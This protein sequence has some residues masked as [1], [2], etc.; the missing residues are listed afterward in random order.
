[1]ASL[2]FTRNA[3][4]VSSDNNPVLCA[5]ELHKSYGSGD[6]IVH[7]VAGVDVALHAGEVVAIMGAS[8]S[9]KTT[10]LH[11]LAGL[12]RADSGAICF[13]DRDFATL[14]DAQL[15]A[16]RCAELSI[17]FQ[18]YN[19]LP[20]LTAIDNVALP[21]LLGGI[22]R[23]QARQMA[24][25]KLS[26]VGMTAHARRRPPQLSGGEQQR[27]AIARALVNEP[28]VL[29]AD[30]PTGNLDRKN[31]ESVCQLL[32]QVGASAG[33]AVAIVTHDPFVAAYADRIIV[34][35][36]GRLTDSFTRSEVGGAEGIA[37]RY[38]SAAA[39]TPS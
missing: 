13:D 32:Q 5:I 24:D 28:R 8:G 33:R 29:L 6:A 16:L 17:I 26:Q 25:D 18:A 23:A 14:S 22:N 15:T 21:L 4:V 11:L 36:D 30:E 7:A 20:T 34:L 35:V 19:L 27:V 1:M 31:A 10:L 12:I 38:L 39:A 9:G 3:E 37:M 2:S